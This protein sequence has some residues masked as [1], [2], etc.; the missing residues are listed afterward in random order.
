[1]NKTM[2]ALTFHYC[3]EVCRWSTDE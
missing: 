3:S 1:M 2:V